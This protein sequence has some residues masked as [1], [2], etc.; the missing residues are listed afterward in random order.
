M[1][2]Y[3]TEE[4]WFEE[5][6]NGGTQFDGVSGVAQLSVGD[7]VKVSGQKVADRAINARSVERDD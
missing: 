6:E 7:L 3:A 4:L 5:K 1:M 2:Y